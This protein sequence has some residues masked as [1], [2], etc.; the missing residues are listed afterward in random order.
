MNNSLDNIF[1]EIINERFD[2]IRLLGQGGMSEVYLAQDKKLPRKVAIK[3]ILQELSAKDDVKKRIERE[4]K[5]HA[6]I[7]PHPNIVTLFDRI[8]HGQQIFLIMEYIDGQTLDKWATQDY[9]NDQVTSILTE[10]L[11]ALE[12]I[13]AHNVIHRDIK[14]ENIMVAINEL[15]RVTAKLMDFG[16]SYDENINA[17]STKLTQ[18]EIGT[19]GSPAYMSPE[20]IDEKT[21]GSVGP[22]S[23]LYAVGIILYELITKSPP[24]TGTMTQILT[25]HLVSDPDFE[26]TGIQHPLLRSILSKS[27]SKKQHNRYAAAGEFILDLKAYS[28]TGDFQPSQ[29]VDKTQL[30]VKLDNTDVSNKTQ[31]H[32]PTQ[33]KTTS[34]N[35]MLISVILMASLAAG[36]FAYYY[37]SNQQDKTTSAEIAKS[38]D[39]DIELPAVLEQE[40]SL[41]PVEKEETKLEALKEIAEEEIDNTTKEE[42]KTVPADESSVKEP[43]TELAAKSQDNIPQTADL[44]VN[45]PNDPS[46]YPNPAKS[47]SRG[48]RTLDPLDFMGASPS[49]DYEPG[50]QASDAFKQMREKKRGQLSSTKNTTV[51]TTTSSQ[52]KVSAPRTS[53]TPDKS[54]TKNSSSSANSN[55]WTVKTK[56]SSQVN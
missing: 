9:T 38:S 44:P 33:Q 47:S 7:G 3:S 35:G 6:S 31:L 52:A 19:P 29:N 27:L 16:I 50:T 26:K 36:G 45:N 13:H 17:K 20:Q 18:I 54:K 40:I 48:I 24:F 43:S 15:G 22:A 28:N 41:V 14:P 1:P 55:G 32:I 5:I 21:F 53:V 46:S 34:S 56:S 30:A 2:V 12:S 42:Q 10:I 39:S 49:Y 11:S 37:N 51:T 8:E 25:G 23:D 4:V